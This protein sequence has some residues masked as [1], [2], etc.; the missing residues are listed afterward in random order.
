MTNYHALAAHRELV[1]G[2]LARYIEEMRS[3]SAEAIARYGVYGGVLVGVAIVLAVG[4][5]HVR[6]RRAA[7][8]ET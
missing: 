8:Y 1:R 3:L 6:R 7:A 4:A 5:L 2:E